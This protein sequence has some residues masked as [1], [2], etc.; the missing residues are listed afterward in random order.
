MK[1][2]VIKGK[3]NKGEKWKWSIIGVESQNKS[4]HFIGKGDKVQIPQIKSLKTEQSI[5]VNV[6]AELKL[7]G[8]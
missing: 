3:W 7:K 4:R 5:L 8:L 6:K 1:R 2:V